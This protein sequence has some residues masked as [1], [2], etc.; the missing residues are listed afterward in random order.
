MKEVAYLS[1]N[2]PGQISSILRKVLN[3]HGYGFQY[4][5]MRRGE[6]LYSSRRSRW[7][8]DVAEFPV[9][10]DQTIHIDFLLKSQSGRTIVVAECKRADPAKALWCFARSPYNWRNSDVEEV[11]FEH[12][13]YKLGVSINRLPHFAVSTKKTYDLGFD[14]RTGEKGDGFGNNIAAINSAVTQV[15]RGTSGLINHIHHGVMNSIGASGA[16][17]FIPAIFTTAQIWITDADLGAAD[18]ATGDLDVAAIEAKQTDWI[19]FTHNR[20]PSLKPNI[21]IV[22]PNNLFGD[23]SFDIRQEFARSIAIISVNGIDNF[24]SADLENWLW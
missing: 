24:L 14:L 11:S 6:E 23:L 17:I 12:L 19:W 16:F 3:T 1:L 8:F 13:E 9:V 4:A 10:G 22:K 15:L 21:D 20:S 7:V 5:V 18:P 2:D